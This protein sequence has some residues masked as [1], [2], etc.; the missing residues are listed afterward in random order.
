M[1]E[2][3]TFVD[4]QRLRVQENADEIPPG[5]MPRSVDVICRNEI[6]EQA[7][8]GDKIVFTGTIAVVPDTSGLSRVGEATMG[9]KT[10]GKGAESFGDGVQGLKKLGVKEMTYKMIFIASSVQHTDQRTG[11]AVTGGNLGEIISGGGDSDKN[12]TLE[13]SEAEKRE[14]IEMRNSSQLY[15]KMVESVCPSV[16]GHPD[17]KRGV[18]LMLFGGVH[19]TT[20]EGIS[21][22]GEP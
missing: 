21:L 6:V 10:Q 8:A 5:S 18:L 11:G 12:D 17:V 15:N 20:R 2:Q 19:K 4:W 22:R 9:G 13:L 16:F 14:I 1:L 3:S 7:K